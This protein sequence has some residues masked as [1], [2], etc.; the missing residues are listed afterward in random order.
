MTNASVIHFTISL[1]VFFMFP[2]A[3]IKAAHVKDFVMYI[4]DFCCSSCS[5]NFLF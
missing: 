1:M 5:H 2:L 4:N 3:Y